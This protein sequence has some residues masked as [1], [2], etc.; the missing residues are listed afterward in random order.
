MRRILQ[1]LVGL[2]VLLPLSVRAQEPSTPA[3]SGHGS[4]TAAHATKG[5]SQTADHTKFKVL[6]GPFKDGDGSAVTRACLT[7]HTKAAEQ[8]MATQHWKW[9]IPDAGMESFGK[10]TLLVNNYCLTIIGGNTEACA[11][12]HAGYGFKDKTFDFTKQENVDCLV[13]HDTTGDYEKIGAGL[14][15]PAVPLVDIA[16][17][18]GL[19][20]LKNCGACHFFGGG[21]NATKHGDLDDSILSAP[22]AEDVHMSKQGA[23]MYCVDCHASNSHQV[24]GP[25]YVIPADKR[26]QPKYPGE[27]VSRMACSA[28]HTETPHKSFILNRHYQKVACQTCH[29]PAFARGTLPTNT[30]WDWATS[31]RLKDGRPYE[32]K[33]EKGWLTYTSMR[34]K[35]TWEQNVKPNYIWYNGNLKFTRLTDNLP[36]SRPVVLN[37][38]EG[39]YTDPNAKI[40]PFKFHEATQPYDPVNNKLVAPYTD[41]PPG[42]GAFWGDWKMDVAIKKGMETAGL[43]Y[44]GKFDYIHTTMLW[45]ITHMVAPK[46]QALSCTECHTKKGRLADVPGFYLIGRDRG[47]G[48]DFIGI[49]MIILTILGVGTHGV[50]RYLHGRH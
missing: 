30:F 38:A 40:W 49:A 9:H 11:R 8:V 26:E 48:I 28:C 35:M 2:F 25:D 10:S 19:P 23:G 24:G 34:G 12:C 16:Q 33:N 15:N 3:P 7:C 50:I 37:P 32:E 31:G 36:A 17:K 45:P 47:T 6:Q 1:L 22:R 29:I 4:F 39:S 42:S 14:P 13:C 44:S 27:E 46:E 21:A 18:V 5:R 20:G 43:P 41:G